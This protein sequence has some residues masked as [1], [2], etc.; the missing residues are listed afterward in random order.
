[1][2]DTD[3][4]AS[5]DNIPPKRS[6]IF[7]ICKSFIESILCTV[8]S[9]ALMGKSKTFLKR[10]NL[11]DTAVTFATTT[12]FFGL[13]DV[14]R[15]IVHNKEIDELTKQKADSHVQRYEREKLASSQSGQSIYSK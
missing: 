9:Y 5:S 14:S 4:K 12:A 8:A 2:P 13:I 7:A 3:K 11:K 1:M 10:E 6:L 15:V